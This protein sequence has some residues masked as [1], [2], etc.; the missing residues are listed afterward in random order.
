MSKE[1]NERFSKCLSD[2]DRVYWNTGEETFLRCAKYGT[3]CLEETCK[4]VENANKN[5]LG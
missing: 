1:F 3:K 4:E 2:H 5:K